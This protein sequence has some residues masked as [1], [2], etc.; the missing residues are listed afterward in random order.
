MN[1][2]PY[3]ASILQQIRQNQARSSDERFNAMC[4]LIDAAWSL[5]PKNPDAHERRLRLQRQR[6]R[7]RE[8][9]R[10]FCRKHFR[11]DAD[12]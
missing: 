2:T 11:P 6:E 7:E 9:L 4:D 12:V 8:Q 5:A 1:S 10:E 3:Q